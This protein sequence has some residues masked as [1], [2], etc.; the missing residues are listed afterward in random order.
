MQCFTSVAMCT[1]Y[2][3]RTGLRSFDSGPDCPLFLS[4]T[5]AGTLLPA[6]G[7]RFFDAGSTPNELICRH[8][9]AAR[10]VLNTPRRSIEC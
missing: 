7:V 6:T 4:W 9:A 5:T 10:R 2:A 1:T 3:N 8:F